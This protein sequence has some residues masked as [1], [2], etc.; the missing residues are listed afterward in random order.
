LETIRLVEK[1]ITLTHYGNALRIPLSSSEDD[2][3]KERPPLI[4]PQPVGGRFPESVAPELWV[5]E[6]FDGYAVDLWS[7]GIALWQ[8]TVPDNVVQLFAAP[9]T[10]DFRFREYCVEGKLK[11]QLKPAAL[12][13]TL[14]DLLEGLLRIKPNERYTLKDV[15]EHAWL[16]T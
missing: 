10:D 12:P 11:E 7:A 8:M 3:Y 14:V 1:H 15:L 5:Q 16:A 2:T 9:I 6:P 4:S 13:D